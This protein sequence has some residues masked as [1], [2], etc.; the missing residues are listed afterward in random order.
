VSGPAVALSCVRV[1]NCV[2]PH[3]GCCYVES[4]AAQHPQ[5][6]EWIGKTPGLPCGRGQDGGLFILVPLP[7]GAA[8][9]APICPPHAELIE[10]LY[11]AESEGADGA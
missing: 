5:A 2:A 8:V 3:G 10:S 6:A 11:P 1:H 9:K 7:N 4:V